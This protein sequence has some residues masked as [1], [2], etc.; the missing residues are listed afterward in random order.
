MNSKGNSKTKDKKLK[1]KQKENT[2]ADDS[3]KEEAFKYMEEIKNK[4]FEF[5]IVIGIILMILGS[6]YF[7]YKYEKK[8]RMSTGDDDDTNHYDV[9]GVDPSIDIK[10]LKKKYKELAKV[11]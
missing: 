7:Q 1:D 9:L 3:I 11:W 6:V 10:E 8:L 2:N 4:K 5:G